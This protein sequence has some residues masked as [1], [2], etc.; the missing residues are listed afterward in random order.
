MFFTVDRVEKLTA[1]MDFEEL[2]QLDEKFCK[3]Y[4]KINKYWHYIHLW[5]LFKKQS[6]DAITFFKKNLI[7]T[8]SMVEFSALCRTLAGE[9]I[10]VELDQLHCLGQIDNLGATKV[11]TSLKDY[12]GF[13]RVKPSAWEYIF[14]FLKDEHTY[15]NLCHLSSD[16]RKSLKKLLEI[17]NEQN[18]FVSTAE[19]RKFCTEVSQEG[20]EDP[21]NV[22]IS[23]PASSAYQ[24]FNQATLD[25]LVT[26]FANVFPGTQPVKYNPV[27]VNDIVNSGE[28]S[29]TCES[30]DLVLLYS[31]AFPRDGNNKIDTVYLRQLMTKLNKNSKETYM[32]QLFLLIQKM[33]YFPYAEVIEFGSGYCDHV[34]CF[35]LQFWPSVA[36]KWPD[37]KPRYW[38]EKKTVS[39]IVSGGC[40]IVPKSPRG[41]NNNEW[42]TSF[43]AAELILSK[44][45]TKFQRKCYLV[46]KTIYY[47]VI[48]N[49][50]PDVFASY[51][52]KTLMFKLM[53]KQPCSFWENSSLTEVDVVTIL[54]KDLSCCFDR[55]IL[56]S[57]F[58][59]DLNLLERIENDKLTL[60][61]VK[62]AAV[63]KYPLKC[64]PT[65]YN[66]K[67]NLIKKAISFGEGF[68]DGLE[69]FYKCAL[70]YSMFKGLDNTPSPDEGVGNN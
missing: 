29:L 9:K 3:T 68:G 13:F 19:I 70:S 59:D 67:I 47:T 58:V 24:V 64:L 12:P 31:K 33:K 50:D 34:P 10:G 66:Q 49:I 48:K 69:A 20:I 39:Q 62:A 60:A 37:R 65:S 32:I 30:E 35:H 55:K 11:L 27:S 44:T 23:G 14:P 4:M 7:I 26:T 36:L 54:F 46:A 8:G 56:T 2:S 38:P 5:N 18:E 53:E 22:V 52:L 43:S 25:S 45:L 57:F 6:E 40:H 28:D 16:P 41:E 1:S 15:L 63:A 51:F 17:F 21:E 42:R 61:S